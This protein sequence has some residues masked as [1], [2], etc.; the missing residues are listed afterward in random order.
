MI[1]KSEIVPA[2]KTCHGNCWLCM[3]A[4]LCPNWLDTGTEVYGLMR[5]KQEYHVALCEGRH[6]IPGAVDG[7]IFPNTVDPTDL[8]GLYDTAAKELDGIKK[9]TVY[10]TGMTQALVAV[11]KV[12]MKENISLTVMYYDR[13]TGNYISDEIM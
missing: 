1:K 7:S 9:V 5:R 11:I 4:D 12:C 10:V 2:C 3:F 6:D 8:D 13:E